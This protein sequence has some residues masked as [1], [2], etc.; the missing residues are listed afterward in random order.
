VNH[1]HVFQRR[2]VSDVRHFDALRLTGKDEAQIRHFYAGRL[3]FTRGKNEKALI[4]AISSLHVELDR[5]PTWAE[6]HKKLRSAVLGK[7]SKDG[8][9]RVLNRVNDRIPSRMYPVTLTRDRPRFRFHAVVQ[10]VALRWFY[11]HRQSATRVELISELKK[12]K[13]KVTYTVLNGIL[14]SLRK[15]A[16]PSERAAFSLS[17]RRLS[18]TWGD[19]VKA[20]KAAA[21]HL[22]RFELTR[23]PSAVEVSAFLAR[24]GQRLSARALIARMRNKPKR[25]KIRLSRYTDPAHTVLRNSH[26]ALSS[27]LRRPPTLKE[28]TDDFNRV[29]VRRDTTDAVW[30]RI[31]NLNHRRKSENRLKLSAPMH[32]GLYDVDIKN[33]FKALKRGLKRAPTFKELWRDMRAA[34]PGLKLREDSFWKRVSRLGLTCSL[35][36]DLRKK[37]TEAIREVMI[38][39]RNKFGRR[40]LRSEVLHELSMRGVNLSPADFNRRLGAVKKR[41]APGVKGAFL[42]GFSDYVLGKLRTACQEL[43]SSRAG[44]YPMIAQVATALGWS[45]SGVM[46][47]LPLAQMREAKRG[48]PPTVVLDLP[49]GGYL[50]SIHTVVSSIFSRIDGLRLGRGDV[51][52]ALYELSNLPTFLHGWE[53]PEVTS[54]VLHD[55]CTIDAALLRCEVAWI[56]LVCMYAPERTISE[57]VEW[58]ARS[59]AAVLDRALAS[60]QAGAE[61]FKGLIHALFIAEHA[62][63]LGLGEA[64]RIIDQV[65]ANSDKAQ[66]WSMVRSVIQELAAQCGFPQYKPKARRVQWRMGV[67]SAGSGDQNYIEPRD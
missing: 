52:K 35:P 53:L 2:T 59:N 45:E 44:R 22:K 58:K 13:V 43:K 24:Q 20:H 3:K 19:V 50:D 47:A 5:P 67:S 9:R 66:G 11:V 41:V 16:H 18:V 8:L 60:Q 49:V 1:L 36:N 64:E 14:S 40:A 57:E 10:R 6:V 17:T 12:E 26:K 30:A 62:G 32:S 61:G 56:H 55:S 38:D 48:V 37:D 34:F 28:L 46:A 42:L 4:K 15:T 63:R 33:R 29:M 65:Q 7:L 51:T 25:V 21:L 27:T 23:N 54:V 39:L 31:Q